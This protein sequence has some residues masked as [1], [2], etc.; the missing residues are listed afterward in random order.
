MSEDE[1]LCLVFIPALVAILLKA[2]KD[3][4]IP[5]TE[6]EVLEIRGSSTCMA[7]KFSDALRMDEE[8]GYPDIVPEDAWNEW[9]NVRNEV[10]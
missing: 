10:L 1:Q 3:K 2:E 7:V 8:R 4:G 5:L 6:D 9:R